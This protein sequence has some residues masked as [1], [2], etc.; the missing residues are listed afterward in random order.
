VA[1]VHGA[2]LVHHI[3]QLLGSFQLRR[4]VVPEVFRGVVLLR[5]HRAGQPE[6]GPVLCVGLRHVL[7]AP[8][9]SGRA[10]RHGARAGVHPGHGSGHRPGQDR[11]AIVGC[12]VLLGRHDVRVHGVHMD[13]HGGRTGGRHII[14]QHKCGGPDSHLQPG[15]VPVPRAGLRLRAHR[16]PAGGGRGGPPGT[17][18]AG[19]ARG[20]PVPDGRR[21]WP[22]GEPPQPGVHDDPVYEMAVQ[23]GPHHHGRVPHHRNVGRRA[24]QR[25]VRSHSR[26]THRRTRGRDIPVPGATVVFLLHGRPF[27]QSGTCVYARR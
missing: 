18:D 4:R 26:R 6:P 25:A 8:A 14:L 23:R 17:P 16:S 12:Q 5:R 1:G 15:H 19:R 24:K 7:R 22:T 3:L 10:R 13:V 2:G 11:A 21:L 27:V 20:P 9:Q